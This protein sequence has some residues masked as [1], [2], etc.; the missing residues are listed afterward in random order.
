M[1]AGGEGEG[2]GESSFNVVKDR[3][4]NCI[5]YSST[6]EVN[7]TSRVSPG[8]CCN[9]RFRIEPVNNISSF[10]FENTGYRARIVIVQDVLHNGMI[11]GL[12]FN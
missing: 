4:H 8:W 2:G 3:R 1:G 11:K 12:F 10:R 6:V 7:L 9:E 5:N